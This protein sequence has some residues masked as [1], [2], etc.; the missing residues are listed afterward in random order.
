MGQP[1][2]PVWAELLGSAAALKSGL[3]G[4][5][6]IAVTGLALSWGESHR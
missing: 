2:G 3:S 5:G 1:G 6:L 4:L